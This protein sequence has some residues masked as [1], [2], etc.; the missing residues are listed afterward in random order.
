DDHTRVEGSSG[1]TAVDMVTTASLPKIEFTGLNTIIINAF[2][3]D[4]VTFKTELLGGALPGNYKM[5]ASILDTLIIEGSDGALAE[6]FIVT[7]PTG[8]D[9]VAVTDTFAAFGAGVIVTA[10]D[11]GTPLGRLQLNTQGGDDTV[12]VDVTDEAGAA[13]GIISVP[14]TSDGGLV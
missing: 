5:L 9:T 14:I 8:A 12:T 2:G 11:T 3:E 10:V 1:G 6:N 7:N 4:V 13:N